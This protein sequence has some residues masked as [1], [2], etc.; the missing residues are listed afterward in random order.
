MFS[1]TDKRACVALRGIMPATPFWSR[2]PEWSDHLTEMR[3]RVPP[4][5]MYRR[6][7]GVNG[8]VHAG[9]SVSGSPREHEIRLRNMSTAHRS[10]RA[11]VWLFS[12]KLEVAG[13]NPVVAFGERSSVRLE[14]QRSRPYVN[15]SATAYRPE[16]SGGPNATGY[17]SCQEIARKS[18]H[19]GRNSLSTRPFRQTS[20]GRAGRRPLVILDIAGSSPAVASAMNFRRSFP[21]P[22]DR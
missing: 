11:A 12:S 17:L 15:L 16:L 3:V 9:A 14:H 7:V 20:S 6:W 5:V 1:L 8:D 2:G 19:S 13:S 22:L 18:V 21:C 10:S 4:S